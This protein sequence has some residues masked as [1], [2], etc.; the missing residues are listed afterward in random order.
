MKT[1]KQII[2]Q[3]IYLRAN[4]NVQYAAIASVSAL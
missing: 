4:I 1:N 3:P 2:V